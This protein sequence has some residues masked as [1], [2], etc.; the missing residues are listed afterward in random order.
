MHDP[1]A[2]QKLLDSPAEL[3]NGNRAGSLACFSTRFAL[4]FNMDGTARD[5]THT[6]PNTG[7]RAHDVVHWFDDRIRETGLKKSYA[8]SA[9]RKWRMNF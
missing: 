9:R 4:E 2:K 3:R 6:Q 7:R 5:I 8:A 1:Y